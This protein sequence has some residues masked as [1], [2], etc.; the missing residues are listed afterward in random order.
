MTHNLID[1]KKKKE[2]FTNTHKNFPTQMM[3]DS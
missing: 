3:K 1:R 2:E